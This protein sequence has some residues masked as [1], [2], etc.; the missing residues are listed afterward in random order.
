MR[1]SERRREHLARFALVT[2][3]AF[4]SLVLLEIA[5]NVLTADIE[6]FHV[7]EPGTKATFHTVRG[8]MPGVHGRSSFSVNAEGMRGDEF[9]PDHEYRILTVGGSTT[10]C[11][12]LDQVETWPHLLQATLRNE[13]GRNVFVGNIGKSGL[14]SREHYFQLKFLLEQYPDFDMVILLVGIN[15]MSI[16]ISD[17]KYTP[18]DFEDPDEVEEVIERAFMIQPLYEAER[19]SP[20]YKNTDVW[21]AL[22]ILADGTRSKDTVE[23][24]A[25]VWYEKVR[26]YRR[27]A[28]TIIDQLPDIQSGLD[29]YNRNVNKII[30]VANDNAVELIL[31]TQPVMWGTED[32]DGNEDLLWFGGIGDFTKGES[33]AYYS[34][35]ALAEGMNRYN[36]ELLSIC[37]ERGSECLDLASLLPKGTLSFYDDAHFNEAGARA[38]AAILSEYVLASKRITEFHDGRGRAP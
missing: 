9:S 22:E 21:R 8:T 23:D 24:D 7:W 30:D 18:F 29:E 15:D 16:R 5:L 36:A 38:V 6:R 14:N 31:V 17:P 2:G 1:P 20:F 33:D 27:N 11:L 10:E 32:S 34:V 13:T 19:R 3:S 4:A 25:E 35:P 12:Y 28:E 26:S 37:E